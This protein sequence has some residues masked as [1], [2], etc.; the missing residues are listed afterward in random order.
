[1]LSRM[2]TIRNY[3]HQY[4]AYVQFAPMILAGLLGIILLVLLISSVQQWYQDWQLAH[5]TAAKAYV[6]TKNETAEIIAALPRAHIFG[7][8]LSSSDV[9]VTNLQL[10]VT[11]IVSVPNEDDHASSKAYI[12]ISGQPSKIFKMGDELPNGVK[13]YDITADTVI[14][15]HDGDI[16]KLPLPRESLVFKARDEKEAE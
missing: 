11:G 8:N 13:I 10:R 7:Q 6:S 5:Q 16:E 1:M 14:L 4:R 2:T 3:L 15:E 12:S 9:P